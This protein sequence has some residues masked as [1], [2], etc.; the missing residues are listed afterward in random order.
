MTKKRELTK[1]DMQK[2]RLK[3]EE[4][5]SDPKR[6]CGH[7]APNAP[8]G[9]CHNWAGARTD[10]KGEGYC[11]LHDEKHKEKSLA[12]AEA[13][14]LVILS[15]EEMTDPEILELKHEIRLA[16]E[17]LTEAQEANELRAISM[18]LE[19]I[20]KLVDTKNKIELQRRYLIP[21]SVAVNAARRVTDVLAKHIPEEQRFAMRHEVLAALRIELATTA[22]G[23][24]LDPAADWARRKS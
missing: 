5:R 13:V 10:H 14:D 3:A 23:T 2:L 8:D 18:F 1:E 17:K 22:D 16:R 24:W 9:I 12:Q 11:Y 20:R 19:N 7:F 15:E 21:V 6:I 4:A